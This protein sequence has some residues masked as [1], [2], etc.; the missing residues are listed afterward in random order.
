MKTQKNRLENRRVIF[1]LIVA[2]VCSLLF[3]NC[4]PFKSNSADATLD[5]EIKTLAEKTVKLNW[6]QGSGT[7]SP[8]Y[9]YQLNYEFDFTNKTFKLA[10]NKGA[11]VTNQPTPQNKVLTD[12]Q[13]VKIKNLISL[14]KTSACKSGLSLTGGGHE[15]LGLY[16]SAISMNPETVIY[17]TDCVGLGSTN[18]QATSGYTEMLAYLKSL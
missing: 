15:I 12:A 8:D 16:V 9:Q 4:S 7:V 6:A 3:Q 11:L 2:T 1:G 13:I 14:L 18:Y 5:A 10:V 17:G